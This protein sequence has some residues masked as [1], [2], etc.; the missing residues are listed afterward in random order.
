MINNITWGTIVARRLHL[1][2][3]SG[4]LFGGIYTTRVANYLYVP[5][6]RND[7]ELPPAYL[8]YN[9]MVRHQFVE[10]NE[11]F[12]QYRLIFDR[13]RTVHV[14]LPAPTFFDFQAKRRY[15]ITREEANEYER[16]TEAARLQAAAREAVAA[17]SQYDPSYNFGYPPG[18]PWP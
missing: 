4:D 11:Q 8:D 16:R 1:N 14:A 15:V 6:H 3:T 2:G 7:L 10:R 12:L 13:R 17:A 18:Q 9:A 5:I